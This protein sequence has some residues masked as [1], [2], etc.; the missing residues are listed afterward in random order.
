M[1]DEE[2]RRR[3]MQ[4]ARG[5]KP[6]IIQSTEENSQLYSPH[7]SNNNPGSRP[8]TGGSI[9]G[10]MTSSSGTNFNPS[11]TE[12]KIKL[13]G[14]RDIIL[15]DGP[16][17]VL[18]GLGT[19]GGGGGVNSVGTGGGATALR[20][21]TTAPPSEGI[22]N[23]TTTSGEVDTVRTDVRVDTSDKR[24]FVYVCPPR[25]GMVQG[26]IV[27]DKGSMMSQP[28]FSYFLQRDSSF[29]LAAKRPT[30]TASPLISFDEK[31]LSKTSPHVTCK[32]KTNALGTEFTIL[33]LSERTS[34]DALCPEIGAVL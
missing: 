12:E 2:M 28:K 25:S 29:M 20:P 24:K 18:G 14:M 19:V 26:Y 27:R 34:Q 11:T 30:T 7:V 5:N 4:R 31:D 6:G 22:S 16:Q 23:T 17:P 10:L 21:R 13:H 33:D 8:S 15:P 3:A 1:A 9:G 32:V